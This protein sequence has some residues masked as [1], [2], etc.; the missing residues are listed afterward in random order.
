MTPRQ[1][2][3]THNRK[4]R[5]NILRLYRQGRTKQEIAQLFDM[6]VQGVS[7]ILTR[8]GVRKQETYV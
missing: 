3:N 1:T 5:L 2:T 7:V 8:A 4:R 6:T